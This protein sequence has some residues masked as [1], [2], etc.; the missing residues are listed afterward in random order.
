MLGPQ[1]RLKENTGYINI[2]LVR[3]EAH[4]I[5]LTNNEWSLNNVLQLN[6]PVLQC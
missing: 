5:A 2:V 6:P 1:G 3:L 4:I